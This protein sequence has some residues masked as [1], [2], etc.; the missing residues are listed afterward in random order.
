MTWK[1]PEWF[2]LLIPLIGLIVYTWLLRRRRTPSLRFPTVKMF[3]GAHGLRARM[4]NVPILFIFGCCGL[5]I[6]ALA[7]PQKADTKVRKHVEGI[8]IMV[9]LDISDSMGIEDMRP[10]NRMESAKTIIEEFIKARSSD[11]IGLLVF[12]GEAYTRVPLT[13]DY[14]VLLKSLREVKPS[15]NLK[16]GTAI[17]VALASAVSRL[18]DSTAKSRVVILLTDGENNSG[19]IDPETALDIAKGYGIRVYSVGMGQDGM[20]QLP[21]WTK[22]AFGNSVKRYQPMHSAVNDDLLG[23]MAS[24]TGGKYFR[25]LDT[26]ALRKSFQSI[27]SLEKTKIET[28]QYTRFTELY[29]EPLRAAVGIWVIALLL[30][31]LG[32]RRFP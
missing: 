18:K 10:V 24:D 6:V 21:V 11:R 27:N 17:G 13:L 28:N 9:A 1:N 19:T 15:P 32:L 8:D 26:S 31:V 16:M 14:P 25:A 22:D 29:Q 20:A 5:M 12:S 7:R 30:M 4:V 23:K 3:T 2:L